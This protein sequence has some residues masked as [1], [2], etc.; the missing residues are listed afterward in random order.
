MKQGKS[1][2]EKT[3]TSPLPQATSKATAFYYHRYTTDNKKL[4]QPLYMAIV[5][6]LVGIVVSVMF[7]AHVF[8]FTETVEEMRQVPMVSS[9]FWLIGILMILIIGAVLI[10]R[11]YAS[12]KQ[13]RIEKI[14][15]TIVAVHGSDPVRYKVEQQDVEGAEN[16]EEP[17]PVV[18]IER[19]LEDKR[20]YILPLLSSEDI[21]FIT[22]ERSDRDTPKVWRRIAQAMCKR[23][24]L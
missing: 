2:Q 12:Y 10:L 17:A 4:R 16:T 18:T 5:V 22:I 11:L 6:F 24:Q 7:L 23:Y 3:T 15:K 19:W 1:V 20:V 13:C 14:A 21:R 9:S 8:Y